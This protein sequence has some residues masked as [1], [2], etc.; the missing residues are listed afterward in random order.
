M[1]SSLGLLACQAI[2]AF[3][4]GQNQDP[5]VPD[6]MFD[7]LLG[8]YQAYGYYSYTWLQSPRFLEERNIML[9]AI[10]NLSI[11]QGLKKLF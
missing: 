4:G 8:G 3:F 7:G 1:R 11:Q 5:F 9:V 6:L 10:C 2:Y